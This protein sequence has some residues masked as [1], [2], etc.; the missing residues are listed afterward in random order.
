MLIYTVSLSDKEELPNFQDKHFLGNEFSEKILT[1][2]LCKRL[3]IAKSTRFSSIMSTE[4]NITC[5][6]LSHKK[7]KNINLKFSLNNDI[8]V[9][10]ELNNMVQFHN[11]MTI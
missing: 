4:E 6:F 1:Q 3:Q 2:S 11:F 9:S 8:C 7:A 5:L 10:E